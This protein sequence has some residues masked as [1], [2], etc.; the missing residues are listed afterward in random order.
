MGWKFLTLHNIRLN[1]I[2][3]VM[4]TLKTNNVKIERLCVAV[5]DLM[6]LAISVRLS[7]MVADL[8]S[9]EDISSG[10]ILHKII[11]AFVCYLPLLLFLSF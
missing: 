1:V 9:M 5:A 11:F 2:K 4:E 3:K 8:F 7:S 10:G 6:M